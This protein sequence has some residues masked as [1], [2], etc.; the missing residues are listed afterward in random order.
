[1]HVKLTPVG[2][3]AA[4]RLLYVDESAEPVAELIQALGPKLK[5][6]VT[7]AA[8]QS[9]AVE[10]ARKQSFDVA[11]LSATAPETD[12]PLLANELTNLHLK[13]VIFILAP[14][15]A[16]AEQAFLSGRCQVLPN[17][18]PAPLLIE[19]VGRTATLVAWLTN[20]TTL[21]LVSGIHSLPTIPA[22]YQGVLR[23]IH[24]PHS[25][26]QD[27]GDAVN[28]DMGIT[29]RVLQVANSA[30]Y[31]Y[32]KKITN[33][34]EAALLLGVET[35][36]SLVR[37][38]HLLNNFPHAPS[39]GAI[40]DRVWRHS[41]GVGAVARKITLLQTGDE[42]MADEAFTA[43]LLHDIGK[44]ALMSIK[45]EE[46]KA[47]FREAAEGKT[48]GHLLERVKLGTTH[49]ETGAYLMSLWGIPFDILEAVAW[50][51]YPSESRTEKF[52]PLTAVHVANVSEHL[53]TNPARAEFAPKL[54]ERYLRDIAVWEQVEEW[55]KLAP[56]DIK[57][58]PESRERYVVRAAPPAP[59]PKDQSALWYALASAAAFI[60]LVWF[61]WKHPPP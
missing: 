51:H 44:L 25:S 19:A 2:F 26:F 61:I 56:D 11:L 13:I 50:H 27:I 54:D 18:C 1:M 45:P 39:T 43:G 52:S 53:R 42:G 21:E 15:S 57:R 41:A 46:Y 8:N 29:S 23:A 16:L 48:V 60:A 14:P 22:N 37:Y 6:S 4:L 30:F 31:G 47:I 40:F 20:N 59:A 38:T 5:W 36:K 17:P 34:T 3:D 58:E 10:I 35:L 33:P 55:M 24:S 32:T 49:A 12:I 28:K 9:Q 7:R